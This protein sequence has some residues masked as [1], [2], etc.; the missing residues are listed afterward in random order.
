M[1]EFLRK[2]RWLFLRGRREIDL[3]DEIQFHLEEEAEARQERG[4]TPQQAAYAA[5]R[6]LGN[7]TLVREDTRAAWTWPSLE[8]LA[9]DIRYTFRGFR[10][11]PAFTLTACLSLAL[12]LGASLAIYT[13]A[14]N[15]LLRPLPYANASRLVMLWEQKGTYQ[16]GIVAPRNYFA[17]RARTDAFTDMAVFT[18]GHAV[19]TDS[20]RTEELSDIAVEPGV[21]DMLGPKPLIGRS[22]TS[23][24]RAPGAA[25]VI[26]I[27][28]RLWQS[29]FA[30]DPGVIGRRVQY[31]G[32]QQTIAGVLPANF[33]FL[34][35]GIDVWQPLTIT[36]AANNGDGRW[37]DCLALLKPGVSLK[38][39]QAEITEVARQRAMQD[40]SFSKGWGA[41]VETLRN[42]L[43]RQ[44]KPSL[45]VLLGAVG[46]LLAV[47]CANVASLLLARYTARQREIALRISLGAGRARVIRQLLTESLILALT[48]GAIGMLLARI[49]VSALVQL[50][51]KDLTQAIAIATDLRV[52][53]FALALTALTSI[54]FGLAP[55]LAGSRSDLSRQLQ[56]GGR[57]SIGSGGNLRAWFVGAEVAIS[58]VLLSGALL[59]FRT[60]D[61]LQNVNP[62]LRAGHV[63]TLRVSLPE[64][65]YGHGERA[66]QFFESAVEQV[67]ALPGVISASAVSHLPF[68]GIV[69]ATWIQISGEP[70]SRPGEEKVAAIRT[71]LPGY[72][73]T[74][75][76]PFLAGRDFTDADNRV[77]APLRFIV[78][79]QF[80]EKFL[81]NSNP[82][83]KQLRVWMNVNNPFGQ[84]V[85]VVDDVHDETLED[86]PSPTVYYPHAQLA[87]DQM[88]V[89]ART[90]ADPLSFVAPIRR[91]VRSI[92]SA[93]PIADVKTMDEVIA[94]TFSRQRFSALLLAGFSCASLLLAA[95]GVY[96]ILAYWVS[97]RVR[98]IGVRVAVGATP[99]NIRSLVFRSAAVPVVA[100]VAA[101]ITGALLLAGLVRTLLFGVGP[102]D[103]VTLALAPVTLALVALLAAWIPSRRAAALDPACALRAG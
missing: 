9:Q 58:V 94:N 54:L 79:R 76:I 45:L 59:F 82:L 22:L 91:I 7:P 40:P 29:W 12:G 68:N 15:L 84:I 77:S 31:G 89:L 78:S 98:E 56:E 35:R 26:L 1:S 60:L 88:L 23:A 38:R 71:V 27:S 28:Y 92:D 97:E 32:K 87:Y 90:A 5:R 75:G 36:P 72:F 21:L 17:W 69:P 46:L 25:P 24:D 100:G 64:T 8:H 41:E 14:D 3:R 2:L 95:I 42:A 93:Q 16:H 61:K 83:D 73:R 101:G 63:L 53:L 99:A 62:G 70:P 43:V 13:V 19:L 11:N 51:P 65:R 47:A 81:R 50:A 85:G 52:Y 102:H 55:A 66:V 67:R 48:G 96:G 44:V 37:L 80:V 4:A 10:D 33:Y 39:A 103:P 57:S 34:D 86:A 18:S 20:G 74:M 49:A 6:D 30:G